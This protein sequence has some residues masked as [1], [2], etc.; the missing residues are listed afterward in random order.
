MLTTAR[1][2]FLLLVALFFAP[3]T[4]V[5]AELEMR[6]SV[7]ERILADQLFT[8]EGRLYVRGNK[9][10]RCQFAYLE[11]PH[12]G[13]DNGRLR[14]TASFRGRS[15]LKVLGNCLGPGDSFNFVLT[16][17]PYVH[18]GALA[19]KDVKVTTVKE[20]YYIRRVRAALSTSIEKDLRIDVK[21]QAKRL[22]EQPREK[23]LYQQEL[24]SFQL[25]DAHA[26]PDALVLVVD[27][28]LVLK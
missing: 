12:I 10:Q 9:A 8:Q 13:A 4:G 18:N 15:A 24:A 7:L 5:A 26:A 11:G 27:F 2:A 21:E 17:T 3:I 20:S 1:L 25:S 14:M 28:R 16:A 23:S 22:L 19:L 6:Y